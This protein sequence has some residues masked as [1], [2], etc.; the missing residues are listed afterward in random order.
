MSPITESA[1]KFGLRFTIL[2]NKTDEGEQEVDRIV[3]TPLICST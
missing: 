2:G 1:K 3:V